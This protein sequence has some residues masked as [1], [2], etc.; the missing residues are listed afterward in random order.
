VLVTAPAGF[1][2][3]TIMTQWLAEERSRAGR[4]AWVSLGPDDDD[5]RRFVDRIVAAVT[6]CPPG[7]G[8]RTRAL[9]QTDRAVPAPGVVAS[10]VAELDELD[11]ATIL[12]LDDFHVIDDR[13]VVQAVALLIDQLPPQ[14]TV[15]I[16]T[17]ADPALPLPRLRSRGELIEL[18]A[19]DLRFSAEEA[20]TFLNQVM[21]LHLSPEDVA[22]LE[23]RTE[24][25]PAGLQLAALSL[26]GHDDPTSFVAAF[27][28]SHRFVLD[29]LV[30]EVLN[31]QSERT[32]EFLLDT[33]VLAELTGP[34]C[35][36]LTGRGDGAQTLEEL[37]RGNLFVVPLDDH[38]QRFRYHQ[39]FADMLRSRLLARRPGRAAV[40]HRAASDWYAES[41]ELS[42]A[43]GHALA[44]GD[45]ERAAD[46][47]ELAL[48][49][50][51]RRRENGAMR[52]WLRAL[53][54]EVVR[55]RPVLAVCL[56]WSRLA[57]GD[58]DGAAAWLD[59][60]DRARTPAAPPTD[61]VF[62]QALAQ[63]AR[64]R[65]DEVRTLPAMVAVYRASLAQA[66]G[67]VDTTVAQAQHALDA[68]GPTD[69]FI[70]GAASGFLGLAAWAAGDLSVAVDTFGTAVASLH[71]AGN[72]T[73]ELGA[74]V[75]L[76]GME[77]ARGRPWA[78]RRLYERALAA[79]DGD[80]DAA[81]PVIGDLHVGLAETLREQDEIEAAAAHLQTA[82]E[83]GE[84]ASLPENRFRESAVMAG[85]LQAQGDLEGAAT[86][87]A[88]A[89]ARYLPGFFPDLRPLPAAIARIRIAQG[90]LADAAEWARAHGVT[91]TDPPRYATEFNQLTLA[92][93]LVAQR[94]DAG[95]RDALGLLDRLV[96]AAESAE[97]AGSV[98]EARLVR[99]LA[100][101]AADQTA[102][103]TADLAAALTAGVPAGYR[104]L[105][106][107]E[108]PPMQELLRRVQQHPEAGECARV[109]LG[110]AQR[111]VVT[112]VVRS[113]AVELSERE[114]EVVRLLATDL[115]GPE[116][117]RQL[118]VTVNTLRTH[119]KH[120]FSKLDVTTRRAAVTRAGE[121]GLL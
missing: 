24:G 69:H 40:L 35:D 72:L 83:L 78:A 74:T 104:R 44:G 102:G 95:L 4:V 60:A 36:A 34:L 70:R 45:F 30:E 25:W 92:R 57:E 63:A 47:V 96:R 26:Q 42:E 29:Y 80:P 15:A 7:F 38:R 114:L 93:L 119:T 1:G 19:A 73:D 23:A 77:I 18:R 16:A 59:T 2:K 67:D 10:F 117:A 76:A 111:P 121:L 50:A 89:A 64:D 48:P 68:A 98:I 31:N 37:E 21:G 9:L 32:R 109:L 5:L 100:R 43:I 115:T 66:R 75:V 3:T 53:P 11:G 39:L 6:D 51:R 17:R 62:P 101:H 14:A 120:V 91:A 33:S 46:L 113:V 90:R 107:D 27:T 65:D 52:K 54:E 55:L 56:A 97:R 49:G 110:A 13:A 87:L 79:A 94:T 20:G 8:A 103:A 12:A 85:L 99:A 84:A 41:G 112:A 81:L 106:L 61:R 108:G 105:F 58:L 71:A 118:F 86:M 116:I 88:D 82:R 22:A 28:G